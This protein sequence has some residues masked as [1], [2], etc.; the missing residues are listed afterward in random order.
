MLVQGGG[1]WG[2][3]VCWAWTRPLGSCRRQGL[4][5]THGLW[6]WV[7]SQRREQ[8]VGRVGYSGCASRLEPVGCLSGWSGERWKGL[9]GGSGACGFWLVGWFEQL[10]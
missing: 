9:G 4:R 10:Q 5:G 6:L 8:A 7:L 2:L 1:P 3:L